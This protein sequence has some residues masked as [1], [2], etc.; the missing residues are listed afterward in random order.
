[1]KICAVPDRHLFDEFGKK[2]CEYNEGHYEG[3][4]NAG[5]PTIVETYGKTE[6]VKLGTHSPKFM[7][8]SI[9]IYV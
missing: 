6:L 8:L 4:F 5:I 3:I 2:T 7:K 9:Y 1:M